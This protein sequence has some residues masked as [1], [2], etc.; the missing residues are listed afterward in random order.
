[1]TQYSINKGL[2]EFDEHGEE[3]V[4][5]ELSSLKDMD[6]FF[7]MDT[8]TLT[9]DQ[10]VKA[11]SSLMFLK[12]KRDGTIKGEPVPLALHS[13]HTSRKKMP[14]LPLVPRNQYGMVFY[15]ILL[16]CN[17]IVTYFQRRV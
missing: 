11:I 1:M 3:A 15:V 6:T 12:E 4:V 7:P 13:V 8:E 14:P 2:K 17:I 10:R 16:N 5:K 9:K